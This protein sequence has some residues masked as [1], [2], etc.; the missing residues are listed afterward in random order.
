MMKN[1]WLNSIKNG[2]DSLKE[3]WI[4]YLVSLV[5][6]SIAFM[7]VEHQPVITS[8]WWAIVTGLTIGYGDIYPHTIAGQVLTVIWAHYTVIFILPLFVGR[9]VVSVMDNKNEFTDSEQKKILEILR[10]V[11]RNTK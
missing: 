2:T 9:V 4:I 10:R 11:D 8:F 5:V 3:L 1:K 7:V 6:V